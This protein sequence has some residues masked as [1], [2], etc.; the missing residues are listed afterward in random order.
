MTERTRKEF[1]LDQFL[2][3]ATAFEHPSQVVD[4]PDM[5]LAE[6]RAV[7]A[8]WASDACAV[9]AVPALREPIPGKTVK[10]DEIMEALR[11]LDAQVAHRPDYG[12][13]VS[14]ARR[15]KD[16]FWRNRGGPGEPR[17]Q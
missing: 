1:D 9:E 13:L 11:R 17:V 15:A 4:D 14:R 16:V 7:L 12:K 3:P 6:K 2:H 5:T 8:S 10:F